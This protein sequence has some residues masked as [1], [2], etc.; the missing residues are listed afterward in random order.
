[1]KPKK[2]AIALSE[3]IALS[4]SRSNAEREGEVL[5]S[6]LAQRWIYH[7]DDSRQ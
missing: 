3:A 5:N 7:R 1:M 4:P 6:R 2:G